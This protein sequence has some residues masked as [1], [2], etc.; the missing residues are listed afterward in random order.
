MFIW[1]NHV[2]IRRIAL[3]MS[4]HRVPRKILLRQIIPQKNPEKSLANRRREKVQSN[5]PTALLIMPMAIRRNAKAILIPVSS[6]TILLTNLHGAHHLH[7]VTPMDL[8]DTTLHITAMLIISIHMITWR[9]SGIAEIFAP[10][11][12]HD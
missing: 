10:L 7:T 6:H 3:L 5:T 8:L 12:D 9:E 4:K 1:F 2:P 11:K